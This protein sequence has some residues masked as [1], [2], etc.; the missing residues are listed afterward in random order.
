MSTDALSS[1]TTGR[2]GIGVNN[3]D[4]IT[5]W[6]R[7]YESLFTEDMGFAPDV[8]AIKAG[9]LRRRLSVE[10]LSFDPC[11]DTSPEC[12]R[13]SDG[14]IVGNPCDSARGWCGSH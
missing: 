14:T 6:W 11:D 8:T 7:E 12:S 1:D 2:S 4:P 13:L 9:T 3:D 10:C 5:C